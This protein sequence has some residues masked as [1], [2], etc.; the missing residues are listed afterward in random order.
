MFFL[1]QENYLS[2]PYSES[3]DSDAARRLLNFGEDYRNFIDSQSDWSALSDMSPKFKRKVLAQEQAAEE[4]N[5]DEES[6]K[7]LINDSRDQLKYAQDVFDHVKEGISNV[8][9]EIVSIFFK[10]SMNRVRL[11]GCPLFTLP[12]F[13]GAFA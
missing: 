6:L 10:H 12:P 8:T 13:P 4:S 11:P 7:Q 3:H 1:F 9:S 5:S 2:E